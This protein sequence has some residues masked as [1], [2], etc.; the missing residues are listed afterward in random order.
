MLVTQS[1]LAPT[2]RENILSGYKLDP[3]IQRTD[4]NGNTCDTYTIFYTPPSNGAF[5]TQWAYRF[6]KFWLN[7]GITTGIDYEPSILPNYGW[8]TWTDN[9]THFDFSGTVISNAHAGEYELTVV[10]K[11]QSDCSQVDILTAN[12]TIT[13]NKSP[14]IG[15]MKSMSIN[16]PYEVSWGNG[17]DVIQ[18]PEGDSL[19]I[20]VL[21]DGVAVDWISINTTIYSFTVLAKNENAGDRNV[22]VIVNDVYNTAVN[23]SFTLTI[24]PDYNPF[25]TGK[26]IANVETGI[27]EYV[28]VELFS[29]DDFLFTDL[30]NVSMTA[31]LI[32]HNG[33]PLPSFLSFNPT[34][35]TMYGTPTSRDINDWF[36][37]YVATNDNGD[38]GRI[39]F[40]LSVKPWYARWN[41]CN[42]QEFDQCTLW[43]QNYYLENSQC[44]ITWS[45]NT[46][47]NSA[48]RVCKTWHQ[49]CDQCLDSTQF[50]CT[51]WAANHFFFNNGCYD[52]CPDGYYDDYETYTWQLCNEA[53]TKWYGSSVTQ[54]TEWNS[55][56]LY[57]LTNNN[58]WREVIWVIGQYL[59][60]TDLMCYACD[61]GCNVWEYP[62]NTHWLKCNS[63]YLE[64]TPGTCT[65]CDN[66]TG[67]TINEYSEWVEKCGDGLNFGQHK[68]DDGNLNNGDGWS[69]NWQ[70]ERG[71]NCN[72]TYWWEIIRPIASVTSVSDNNLVTITFSESVL[73]RDQIAFTQNMNTNIDGP[74]SPYKYSTRITNKRFVENATFTELYIQVYE[75]Q[76]PIVGLNKEKFEVWFD[77]LSVIQDQAKN[78][79]SEGKIIGHLNTFEYI[80]PEVLETT[81]NGG[82]SM[83]YTII[84]MF[85]INML[86]KLFIS[87]SASSMWNLIHML[88]VFR[89]ILMINI[90]MPILI[91]VMMDYL[92]IAVGEIDELEQFIPDIYNTYIINSDELNEDAIMVGRFKQNGYEKPYLTDLFGK[93][94]F[95]ISAIVIVGVPFLYLLVKSCT[96][97]PMLNSKLIRIWIDLFW[98]TPIRMFT[99]LFIEISLGFFLQS[100]N[101]SMHYI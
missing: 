12:F 47:Q 69:N 7:D 1:A 13:P 60:S 98:N 35:N 16:V 26:Y 67:Y 40:T 41:D 19:T 29:V 34:N 80:S 25:S 46:I 54:W 42:G 3:D 51:S 22:T 31:S 59:N 73:F 9:S 90:N 36:I 32:L 20:N 72:G 65:H 53:C 55:N 27:N 84:S 93:Q 63:E 45:E 44:K 82:A 66:N 79:L 101:V 8:L 28:L 57:S 58:E 88:Q 76:A 24:N 68:C 23:T 94:A 11:L 14:I 50:N 91:S 38:S 89:L 49:F 5:A 81:S 62:S 71:Y 96:A 61:A 70:I 6:N 18:D 48:T 92:A 52:A 75:I 78:S 39:T 56:L 99:E 86:M 4:A 10:A 85:S 15:N 74:E 64:L 95:V 97:K 2:A 43:Q 83:K 30:M 21:V 17:D 87:S 33:D 100:F 37:A 77:N